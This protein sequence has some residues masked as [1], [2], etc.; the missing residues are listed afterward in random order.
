MTQEYVWLFYYNNSKLTYYSIYYI[1]INYMQLFL[2]R[3]INFL[4]YIYGIFSWKSLFYKNVHK[5][6]ACNGNQKFLLN[7]PLDKNSLVF[8]VG[9]YKWIFT[10]DIINK[11]D[12]YLYI[13]E[14]I[15]EYY[16]I[17]IGKYKDN[18]KVKVYHFGLGKTNGTLE[19]G[20]L[21]DGTSAFK[22]WK[23]ETV[24]IRKFSDFIQENNISNIDLISI[25]I[26]WGEYDL[27]ED[28]VSSGNIH[29]ME[30]I[31]IQFHDFVKNAITLRDQSI[32]A[33]TKSHNKVYTFPFV[34]E[35]FKRK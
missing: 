28:I 33:L 22:K 18:E 12:C 15:G 32:V 1:F 24:E 5:W 4:Q 23:L 20:L 10:D 8:E 17:L 35:G 30:N 14:P 3:S 11:F 31:Q 6:F 13:F 27:I 26:E 29:L 19:L 16:N 9:W 25:N 7:Y 2:S 34:W 21:D